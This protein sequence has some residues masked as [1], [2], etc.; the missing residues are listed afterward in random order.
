MDSINQQQP[1]KN[2]EDLQ[3][4]AAIEKLRELA[5]MTKTCFFCC[6]AS[7]RDWPDVRP[8]SVQKIDEEGRLWFLSADDSHKNEELGRDNR[9]QLL[10]Q[11]SAHSDFLS[12]EG[13]ATVSRD[14]EKIKELWEPIIK[15]WFTGGVDDP[16]IT[17][18]SVA[19]E[20]GYYWDTKHGKAIAFAKMAVGALLG[21]TLDDSI[22]GNLS[23]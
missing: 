4:G 22:E 5:G 1:E 16:R 13:R 18:I 17:V 15:T 11:G 19:P 14:K 7:G 12:I 10:F 21:K 23:L 9:V 3:G 2:H 8:M 6:K 20:T